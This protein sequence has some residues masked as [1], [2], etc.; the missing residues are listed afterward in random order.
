MSTH[1][2]YC[3][4]RLRYIK[5]GLVVAIVTTIFIFYPQFST[6]DS[7]IKSIGSAEANV[8]V[9]L[10][11]GS[12]A[13]SVTVTADYVA[14]KALPNRIKY[15]TGTVGQTFTFAIWDGYGNS[16]SQFNPSVVIA[17][18]YRDDDI[19]PSV[20]SEESTLH[21]HMYN[22][23]TKSW[24]KLCSSVDIYENVVYA[25]LSSS[26]P[27]E[28]NGSNLM[29]IAIDETPML[30]QSLDDQGTTTITF[31]KS[32][33]RLEVGS[34]ILEKG[35]HFVVTILPNTSTRSE[36]KLLSN[37]IDIKAC[38]ADPDIPEQNNREI[39]N[40]F[41][42]LTVG[43]DIDS[44]TTS[45]AGGRSN[46]TIANLQKDEWTDM[47]EV[48]ARVARGSDTITV[49]TRSLGTFGLGAR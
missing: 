27:L 38:K 9:W 21:L 11:T 41:K 19:P 35:S 28:E 45:R 47:E 2:L 37:P 7:R 34:N 4:Q 40:F 26:T 33:F 32:N 31:E 23:A 20:R 30:E 8:S 16:L 22:P 10:P 46:L 29:A 25:A 43:F 13:D 42:P 14:E 17:A 44:D 5:H 6:A 3:K 36:V 48:G 39:T 49:D 24:N 18:S 12:V 1:S 15:P